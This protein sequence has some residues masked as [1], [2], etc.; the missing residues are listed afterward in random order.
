M[1]VPDFTLNNG[2]KIPA[3]AFGA[4][5]KWSKRRTGVE[6]GEID[7]QVVTAL[8]HALENG[9]THIDTAESYNTEP[10]VKL[11]L[12]KAGVD[13]KKLFITTKIN[14]SVA[15]P[16][17]AL[18][19]SL[20]KL[21]VDYVD[22]Y[23]IHTPFS[24]KGKGTTNQQ[25]W[26]TLEGLY[27]SGKAKAIGVS[28]FTI[29]DLEDVLKIAKVKPAVLQ[30]EF[31]AYLQN[32]TPG[33]LK[34]AQENGILVE[35]YGPLGPITTKDADAPLTPVL[36]KLAEKYNKT[37]SQIILRWVYQRGVLAITT[38]QSA[39]RQKQSLDYFDFELS[40]ED[41]EEITNVGSKHTYRQYFIEHYSKYPNSL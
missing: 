24:A 29:E 1:A 36:K 31:S 39:E 23:L 37:T 33:I 34:F 13:R 40:K 9:Y 30:I 17:K 22:L 16:E 4:G 3:V 10:E 2:V 28:N 8:T 32:Q 27:E 20:E 21:G 14:L 12:A 26:K 41:E 19:T 35:A 15:D 25:V 18:N 38:S 6:I 11:A 5:T 7:E